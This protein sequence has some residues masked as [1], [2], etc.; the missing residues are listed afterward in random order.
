MWRSGLCPGGF[1][2][3]CGGGTVFLVVSL[4]VVANNVSLCV[5]VGGPEVGYVSM[6]AVVDIVV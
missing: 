6:G 3:T 1:C 5:Y 4:V 2:L